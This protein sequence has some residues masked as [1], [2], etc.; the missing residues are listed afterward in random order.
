MKRGQDLKANEVLVGADGSRTGQEAADWAA[1]RANGRGLRLHLVRVVPEPSYYRVPARYGEAV[2]EAEALLGLERDRVAERHPTLEIVT[3]WQPGEPEHVLSLLSVGA[4]IVVLG[5]DRSADRRGEGFGSVSFQTAIMC[6]SPVAVIPAPRVVSRIGVVVGIDG[7][8]DSELALKMAAEEANRAGEELTV[9]HAVPKTL[10]S[11]DAVGRM[12][13]DHRREPDPPAL[14]SE[15]AGSVR[16]KFP[17]LTVYEALESDDS[18]ADALIHASEQA[19]LLV[20]GSWGRDGLRKPIGSVAE[21]VLM[22]LPC[23]TIITRPA[24][25]HA[26]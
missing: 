10:T 13:S 5:S 11:A 12:G 21:K 19:I 25:G 22:R 17:A 4:E 2:A 3:S 20:I 26:S 1:H 9:L 7:S 16:E 14:I 23:P 18:P 6:R 15:V 8:A 24:S